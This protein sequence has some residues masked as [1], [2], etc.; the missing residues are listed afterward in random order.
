VKTKKNVKDGPSLGLLDKH[1]AAHY[2]SISTR[3]IERHSDNGDLPFVM[4]GGLRKF[5]PVSLDAFVVR[6]PGKKRKK[7]RD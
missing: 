7:R 5:E 4:V 6:I 1:E 3:G 2:L